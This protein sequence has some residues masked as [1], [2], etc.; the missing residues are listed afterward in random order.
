CGRGF[1]FARG[2]SPVIG[3]GERG[4][5]GGV[6][7]LVEVLVRDSWTRVLGTLEEA[8]LVLSGPDSD[9]GLSEPAF[10]P[11]GVNG[12]GGKTKTPSSPTS[13]DPP[14]GPPESLSNKARTVRVLKQDSGGLGISIKGGRE[15]KMP[16][17]ISRIFPGLA[18]ERS[19]GL[20][21]GDAILAVND[22]DLKEATHDEAVQTLKKC[23]REVLLTV[24]FIR[25]V[26]PFLKK[27][28]SI[29]EL[30]WEVP[31]GPGSLGL[32]AEGQVS[33]NGTSHDK[34]QC[35]LPLKMCFVTRRVNMPDPDNRL[36]EL[37]SPDGT[38]TVVLRCKDSASVHAWFAAL[39]NNTAALLEP[40]LQDS[41]RLFRESSN[42]K[43]LEGSLPQQ[44]HHIGWLTRQV[45]S[46]E[47]DEESQ[48]KA[49]C[50]CPTFIARGSALHSAP[51]FGST[52][53]PEGSRRGA[54]P[55]P[56]RLTLVIHQS[57][58]DLRSCPKPIVFILHSFLSAKV[59]RLGLC[60]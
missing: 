37:H 36:M 1:A 7:G 52:L 35:I 22:V 43:N 34:E 27:N 29:A 25:E 5:R 38:R 23:G 41:N 32:A 3:G 56:H 54:F 42:M 28:S 45:C 17:L 49:L 48:R 39:L 31:D 18:A 30:G 13:S 9:G 15:N 26:T 47:E 6:V 19:G 55:H 50:P 44:I 59:A 24:K 4:G 58:L 60:V 2:A 8:D 12:P 40:V 53:L 16:V 51:V 57:Q 46:P 33:G 21:V 14:D 11:S 20:Y 10:G